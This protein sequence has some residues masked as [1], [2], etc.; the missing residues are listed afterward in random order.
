MRRNIATTP[1][2]E[3]IVA[4]VIKHNRGFN[5]KT[6][7]FSQALQWILADV[8]WCEPDK[9]AYGRWSPVL[10]GIIREAVEARPELHTGASA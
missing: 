7:T 2:M 8:D 3:A 10:G 1:L 9:P 6:L 4:G 5:G